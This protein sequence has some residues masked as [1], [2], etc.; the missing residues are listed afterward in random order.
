MSVEKLWAVGIVCAT[1]LAA[2]VLVLRFM[3]QNLLSDTQVKEVREWAMDKLND[4]RIRVEKLAADVDN[5]KQKL[6]QL[7]NR[8]R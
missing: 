6:T 5:E 4:Q 3:R 7:A 1:L 8:V 2:L